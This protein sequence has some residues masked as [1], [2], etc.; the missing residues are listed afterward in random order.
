M[1]RLQLLCAGYEL[2]VPAIVG[3]DEI[4]DLVDNIETLFD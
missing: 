4:R 1:E 3:H 2:Y